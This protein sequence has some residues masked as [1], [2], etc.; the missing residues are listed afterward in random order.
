MKKQA[1]IIINLSIA[2][3]FTFNIIFAC[4]AE[5]YPAL[6]VSLDETIKRALATN[7]E[8]KIK[9]SEVTKSRGAYREVRSGAL[10]HISAQAT[11]TNNMDFPAKAASKYFDYTLDNGVSASQ[12]IWSFGKVMYAVNSAKKAVEASSFNREASRQDVIYAAKLSYYSNLLAKNTLSITEKSYAN[13]LENKR[14]L[15]QRTYGGRSPK[16]EIIRMNAEAASRVPIVNEART[17][18]DAATETLK[19]IID[20]DPDRKIELTGNF[21]EKYDAFNYETLVAAMYEYE[22][23]LHS[24]SKIIESAQAKVKSKY[25]SFFPTVSAFASWNYRGESNENH[26][27]ESDEL[28]NYSL[29]GI[30]VNIPIWEGGEKEAQL[31]QAK[32][33]KEIAILRKKQLGRN[34][35]LELKKAYLEYEQYKENLKANI[36]AVNLAEESFKQTQEMFA[37]GQVTLTDLNDVELLLTNQRLNKEMTLFNINITLAKIEKLIAGQYDEQKIDKKS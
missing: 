31:I 19:R 36:E 34:L 1:L 4:Y 7:E 14:L 23:S 12:V 35:L 17:Q 37:S 18:F 5:E 13:V 15:G 10:P 20:V 27:L 22:P 25:A 8:L 6:Q 30:K 33:D 26:F 32:A 28:D 2:A 3:L 11:W 24:L 9:D 21:Q 16:Y 29:G